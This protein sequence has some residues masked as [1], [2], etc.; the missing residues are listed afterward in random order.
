MR[1]LRDLALGGFLLVL[2]T[3]LIGIAAHEVWSVFTG[4]ALGAPWIDVNVGAISAIPAATALSCWATI[5]AGLRM[6]D[7][8]ER[9]IMGLSLMCV[10]L[11]VL[12]PLVLI[13]VTHAVLT[14]HGYERCRIDPSRRFPGARYIRKAQS[15]IRQTTPDHAHISGLSF[16][17]ATSTMDPHG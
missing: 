14:G 13:P 8:T 15:P 1:G 11:I 9:R 7:R 16:C 12:L 10:P 3:F 5:L 6:T 17:S 2:C 4:L